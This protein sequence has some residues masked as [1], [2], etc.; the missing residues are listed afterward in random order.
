V[1]ELDAAQ[2]RATSLGVTSTPT[3]VVVRAGRRPQVLT[4]VTDPTTLLAALAAA[5][6]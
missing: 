4:D 2:A 3:L 5:L 6:A 1:A